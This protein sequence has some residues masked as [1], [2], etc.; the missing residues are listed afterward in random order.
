MAPAGRRTAV[1]RVA[2]AAS[3]VLPAVVSAARRRSAPGAAAPAILPAAPGRSSPVGRSV[4][5]SAKVVSASAIVAISVAS[6]SPAS[7]VVIAVSS[8]VA[9]VVHG[10]TPVSPSVST[11]S[12]SSPVV[13]VAIVAVPAAAAVVSSVSS[14][15]ASAAAVVLAVALAGNELHRENALFEPA[16]VGGFL[17]PGGLLDVAELHEGVVPFHVDSHQFPEWFE[18]HLQ[19]FSFR[20]FLLEIHHKESIGRL[21]VLA[22]IVLLAFD[23]PVSPSTLGTHSRRNIWNRHS[24]NR[25]NVALR[26]VLV[27]GGDRVLQKHKAVAPF[28]IEPF[29]G[30]GFEGT[31]FRPRRIEWIVEDRDHVFGLVIGF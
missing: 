21:D 16:A 17:C 23:P 1:S 14:S 22:T 15:P 27:F 9:S 12:V 28:L 26:I 24:A 8:A 11:A 20:G 19:I 13:A 30:D 29:D 7:V 5:S 3:S 31:G 2:S 6:S 18:Q 4:A 10:T 25:R